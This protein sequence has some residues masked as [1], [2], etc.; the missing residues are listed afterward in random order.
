MSAARRPTVVVFG[1]GISGLTVAHE[2]A[3][4]G[5]GV[6][7]VERD[8]CLDRRGRRRIAVGGVARTQY[9]VAGEAR[10]GGPTM[11][12][13]D[14]EG[15]NAVAE[16]RDRGLVPIHVP[17]P[18]RGHEAPKRQARA[19]VD[20]R[21]AALLAFLRDRGLDHRISITGTPASTTTPSRPARSP[22]P[23]STTRSPSRAPAR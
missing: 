13:S 14:P 16:V 18:P 4:R 6:Q 2:L 9:A 12:P 8:T 22:T 11:C 23:R 15:V 5:F 7:V 17:F 20:R 3:E 10:E 21:I 1:A 19:D